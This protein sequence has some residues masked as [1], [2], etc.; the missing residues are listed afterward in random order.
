MYRLTSGER[1]VLPKHS[2]LRIVLS[3][4]GVSFRSLV[5]CFG[6]EG[7]IV[8]EG[9]GVGNKSVWIDDEND[10]GFVFDPSSDTSFVFCLLS[11]GFQACKEI[12]L[13]I[14][15]DDTP[16]AIFSIPAEFGYKSIIAARI[17]KRGDWKLHA[18]GTGS[19]APDVLSLM[20]EAKTCW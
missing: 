2:L 16:V 9:E 13:T 3:A 20:K 14:F 7:G 12:T 15:A 17:Y 10:G 18:I 4:P 5:Y 11:T 1:W 8:G 6:V 19:H